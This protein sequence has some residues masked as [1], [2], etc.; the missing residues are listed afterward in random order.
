MG[1]LMSGRMGTAGRDWGL[2]QVVPERGGRFLTASCDGRAGSGDAVWTGTGTGCNSDL[3]TTVACGTKQR[4]MIW[5][6][7]LD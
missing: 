3:G 4:R 5:R 6:R 2:A 7:T 1:S